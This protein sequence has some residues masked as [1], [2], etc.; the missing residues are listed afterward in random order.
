MKGWTVT[1]MVKR[2]QQNGTLDLKEDPRE[3]ASAQGRET[4]AREW[5]NPEA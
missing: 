3:A 5:E 4:K 1:Q 2:G